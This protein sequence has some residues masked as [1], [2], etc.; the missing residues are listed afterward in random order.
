MPVKSFAKSKL[1]KIFSNQTQK[2][3]KKHKPVIVAVT[4][5]VGKT[6][7]KHA[8]AAVLARK[9]RVQFQEGNYN[10]EISVL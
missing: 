2:I 9:Y 7:T 4:G 3:V 10:T 6:S 8:I 1:E 5:S